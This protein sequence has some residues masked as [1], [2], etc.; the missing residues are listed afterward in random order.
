M[1]RELFWASST[2]AMPGMYCRSSS[3]ACTRRAVSAETLPVLPLSTLD[4]VAVLTPSSSAMSRMR[5]RLSSMQIPPYWMPQ[6]RAPSAPGVHDGR[7]TVMRVP[8]PSRESTSKWPPWRST[9]QRAMARP[10][11]VPPLWRAR[12]GSER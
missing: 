5:T 8:R 6:E 12:A 11:P 9:I 3:S 1:M 10:R 2:P 7:H 4:T